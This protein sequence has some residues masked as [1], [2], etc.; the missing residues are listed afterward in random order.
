MSLS[1]MSFRKTFPITMLSLCAWV[2]TYAQDTLSRQTVEIISAYKPHLRNAV[3]INFAASP[4]AAD[5]AAPRLAYNIPAQNLFFTHSPVVLQ[6]QTLSMD[7]SLLLGTRNYVKAGF[8]NFTTPY[9]E[10]ALGFGNGK[11][12]LLNI[13]GDYISS[14]GKIK[15]QD[16]S[17]INL[18]ASGIHGLGHNEVYGSFGI[19]TNEQYLYGY[20]HDLYDFDKKDIR[21]SFRN[22]S[23]TAGF[24]NKEINDIGINYDPHIELNAFTR[25]N[26]VDESSLFVN[27]PAEKAFGENMKVKLNVQAHINGYKVNSTSLKVNN[28]LFQISP[29]FEYRN[30]VFTLNAGITPSWNNAVSTLLPNIYGEV[31]LEENAIVIQGGWVG[32][33]IANSYRTLTGDNPFIIDPV[34]LLN[35]KEMQYYGGVKATVGSHFNFNAKAAFIRYTDMPLYI[36]DGTDPKDFLLVYESHFN[37]LQIHGDMNFIKQDKFSV[38]AGVD[39]NYYSGLKDNTQAWGLYPM[40]VTGS[41]RWNAMDQL[42]IKGD[43][44]SFSGAKALNGGLE[45]TLNGGTDLSIGAEFKINKMFSAWFDLNNILNSKYEWWYRYPAYGLQAIGGVIIRF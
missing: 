45:K 39:L 30:D 37:D 43:L 41:I 3:K 21:R 28:S 35:T 18:K 33:Y 24:R 7:T 16:F 19:S 25:E 12:G 8:G 26:K 1:C 9:F 15:N 32:R 40:K 27:L 13:Y 23:L 44:V 42:L 38:T 10:G 20:D 6:P 4:L 36:N 17:K 31:Q 14:R 5:T 34:F 22:L 29:S 2:G 11:D